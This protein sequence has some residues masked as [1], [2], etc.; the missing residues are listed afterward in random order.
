MERLAERAIRFLDLRFV[1]VLGTVKSITIPAQ[2]LPHAVR[3]GE[4]FDGSSVEGFAR[5]FES[6]M[7]LRP[8][9]DTLTISEVEGTAGAQVI[10]DLLTPD[11][12]RFAGDPRG[13]LARALAEAA[14]LGFDYAVSIELEFFLLNPDAAGSLARLERRDRASY[15]DHPVDLAGSVRQEIVEALDRMGIAVEASH[16]E[17]AAGQYELDLGL[18]NAL[19]GAD[20]LVTLKHTVKAIAQRR[21]LL[22]TFMPKPMFG[23]AGS[24]M[25]THQVL[26][27]VGRESNAFFDRADQY[28]LSAVARHFIAGQLAHARGL[29]AVVAPLVNSYKR[30]TPGFE[31]PVAITWA[32][33]NRS[34]LIR[35]PRVS[36]ADRGA[37]RI[38]FR[39]PDPS[40]NPYLAFAAMLHA[41]LSGI[42]QKLP[43]PPPVEENLYA[44][45]PERLARHQL[46]QLPG[47]LAEALR[48]LRQDE[49]MREALGVHLLERFIEAKEIEWQSYEKQVSAWELDAYLETY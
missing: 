2:R 47:S 33:M 28:N 25:H 3:Q 21:G 8:D 6:D 43:L 19:R 14:S 9:L 34:A 7:F 48:H 35:V 29:C 32:Q 1:D 42:R 38:E 23:V 10:C 27:E 46:G 39:A 31:A 5:I 41:G 24:G 36:S 11:G 17:V 4:W 18:S 37:I 45:D 20:Q 13:V 26:T 40:C 49:V 22:A 12:E 44:F 16:H 30:F 15:F